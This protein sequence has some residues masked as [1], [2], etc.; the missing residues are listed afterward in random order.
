MMLADLIDLPGLEILVRRMFTV[1]L[2]GV[3]SVLRERGVETRFWSNR[4]LRLLLAS[5]SRIRS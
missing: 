3:P 4:L 2:F 1:M 5:D